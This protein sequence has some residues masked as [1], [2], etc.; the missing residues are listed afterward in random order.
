MRPPKEQYA[1]QGGRH[2]EN[3][4]TNGERAQVPSRDIDISQRPEE[5]E[6][7]PE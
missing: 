2:M 7:V 1:F 6:C 5:C 4:H 3:I